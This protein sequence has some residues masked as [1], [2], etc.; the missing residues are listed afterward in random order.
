MQIELKKFITMRFAVNK[1]EFKYLKMFDE[2]IQAIN[3]FICF[4]IIY[5]KY[6]WFETM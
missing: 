5:L 6:I 2:I 4:V 1:G 3:N